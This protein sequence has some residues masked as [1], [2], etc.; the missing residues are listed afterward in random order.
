MALFKIENIF[1]HCPSRYPP[2]VFLSIVP[3]L[4]K[5][6]LYFNVGLFYFC[7]LQPCVC[8]CHNMSTYA[9]VVYVYVNVNASV[10]CSICNVQPWQPRQVPWTR[11]ASMSLA[12]TILRHRGQRRFRVQIRRPCRQWPTKCLCSSL[13]PRFRITRPPTVTAMPMATPMPMPMLMPMPLP[14]PYWGPGRA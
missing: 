2:L 3:K 10:R 6:C 13:R 4:C 11:T 7:T 14:G 5:L 9:C 8:W 1:I 12:C